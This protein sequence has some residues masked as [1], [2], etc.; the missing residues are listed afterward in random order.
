[1][2]NVSANTRKLTTLAMLAALAIVLVALIHFPLVPAAPFLEYDPA[3]IPIFIGTFLFGPAAG[4]ALTAVVCVIQGVTVSAASGPIGIIMHFL[5]TGTLAM[6]AVM[7][8]CNLVFTP[9]F[10]GSPVGEVV[11][12]LLPAIIPFNLAKAAINSVITY[13]VYKPISRLVFGEKEPAAS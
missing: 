11:K 6:T 4:L 13:L 10:M 3:D 9:L 8:V 5:A 7:C 2:R 1:M 12:L